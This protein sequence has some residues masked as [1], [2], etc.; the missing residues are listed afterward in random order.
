[1]AYTDLQHFITTLEQLKLL[2]RIKAEADSELEIT[3]I[4]DRVVKKGGPALLFENVK[5]SK[6]PL[7][8]NA[9]G[10]QERLDLALQVKDIDNIAEEISSLLDISKYFGIIN[11]LKAAPKLA[12][13]SMV[14][15][16]KVRKA[17]CQ[18]IIEEPDLSTLPI[19]KCWP[20]D[21]GRFITLPLVIT[22]DPDTGMQN[23]GMYRLQVYDGQ[24]T[25][26]HWHMHKDGRQI[27]EK[28]KSDYQE[29][30]D[31]FFEA[32]KE[33]YEGLNQLKGFRTIPS[34]ANY[35]MC[36]ILTDMTAKDIAIQLLDRYNILVKELSQKKGVKG[37]YL[38]L[39]IKK[40]HEN[41][42][43]LKALEEILH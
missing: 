14:F 40:Q 5:N 17:A 9:F 22:K 7:L 12:R 38:R 13:L 34:Q 39:S 28:Y 42:Y 19:L 4:T 25:G 2:K 20:R 33:F 15:P 16:R 32:R 10:T 8:I 37:E 3:E 29:A 35:I 36:E 26:M 1:M 11:K 24:T 41:A 6:Y 18:E 43:L 30:I 31:K 23:M 27:F 21:G